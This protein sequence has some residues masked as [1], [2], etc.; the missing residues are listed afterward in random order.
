MRCRRGRGTNPER[1]TDP[2]KTSVSIVDGGVPTVL[3]NGAGYPR[4]PWWNP[5]P[6]Q[7]SNLLPTAGLAGFLHGHGIE[8]P[9]LERATAWTWTALDAIPDRI[10]AGEWLLQVSYEARAGLTFLDTVPDRDRAVEVADRRGP[11]RGGG[12]ARRPAPG[13][14]AAS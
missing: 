7:R 1:V 5:D 3:S 6:E 4:A 9:W 12:G 8:H 13:G 11:A 14:R 2:D 10:K